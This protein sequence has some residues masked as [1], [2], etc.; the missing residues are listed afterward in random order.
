[1]FKYIFFFPIYFCSKKICKVFKCFSAGYQRIK[2]VLLSMFLFLEIAV[3]LF[4]VLV[5]SFISGPIISRLHA[6]NN[7]NGGVTG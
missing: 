2:I 6:F 1:M 3:M 5:T 4:M 7:P